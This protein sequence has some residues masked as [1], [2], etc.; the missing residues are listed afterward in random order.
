M[1]INHL[2]MA[3]YVYQTKVT[4]LLWLVKYDAVIIRDQ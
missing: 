2:V 3:P 4:N 1:E